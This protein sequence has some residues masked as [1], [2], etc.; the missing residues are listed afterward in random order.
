MVGSEPA[1]DNEAQVGLGERAKGLVELVGVGL[2]VIE[3]GILRRFG[4]CEEDPLVLFGSELG[5]CVHVHKDKAGKHRRGEQR[6]HRAI[7]QRAL[8]LAPVPLGQAGKDAVDQVNK[9]AMQHLAGQQ[10]RTH[11]RRQG[12]RDHAGNDY[13]PGQRE[14]EF[15]EQRAGDAAEKPDRSVDCRQGQGHRDDRAGDLAGTDQGGLRRREALLDVAID[16]LEN[17]DRVVDDQ[18]Y[19]Q[20][21]REQGQQVQAEA[22]R[23]HDNPGADQRQRDCHDR[24]QHRTQAAEEQENHPDHNDD[25]GGERKFDLVDRRLNELGRI[26][27]NLHFDRRRQVAFDLWQQCPNTR[28]Q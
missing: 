5:L 28:H 12:H 23:R 20:H 3:I 9:T 24:N 21:H 4:Q 13:G 6:G 17:D 8:Q 26:V 1:I 25:R 7:I 11:H 10:Q 18:A 22:E 19:R 16:V 27:G 2:L 15:A 14:R